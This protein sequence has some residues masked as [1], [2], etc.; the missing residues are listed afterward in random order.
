M[1]FLGILIASFTTCVLGLLFLNLF[2]YFVGKY[3]SDR[4]KN[5]NVD[6]NKLTIREKIVTLMVHVSKM[7]I[8][9]SIFFAGLIIL[10]VFFERH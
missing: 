2:S 3:A 5:Q 9:G 1:Y 8:A 4:L 10:A 7:P 6:Y